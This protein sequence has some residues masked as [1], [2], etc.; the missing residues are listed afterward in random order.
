MRE[1]FGPLLSF[2]VKGGADAA[3]RVVNALRVIRHGAS[4]GGVESL[5]SLA[6]HT[7]HKMIGPEGRKRAGIPE[8]L[9][10]VSAGIETVD[11]LWADLEQALA[12][13]A[14]VGA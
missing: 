9:V 13:A 6:A 2:D 8:G 4:L 11:D 12:K 3:L 14:V 10:R 5:A 1:G 7:S